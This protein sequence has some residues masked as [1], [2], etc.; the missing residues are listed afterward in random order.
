MGLW[1]ASDAPIIITRFFWSEARRAVH[2]HRTSYQMTLNTLKRLAKALIN[3]RTAISTIYCQLVF[4]HSGITHVQRKMYGSALKGAVLAQD[5]L[6]IPLVSLPLLEFLILRAR[7]C[8]LMLV[9]RLADLT[10]KAGFYS[11][12]QVGRCFR[13]ENKNGA[14]LALITVSRYGVSMSVK[15]SL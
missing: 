13:Y 9:C 1:V 7:K 5:L 15:S 12:F 11:R 6:W 14:K 3:T 2:K 8:A 10:T 4:V